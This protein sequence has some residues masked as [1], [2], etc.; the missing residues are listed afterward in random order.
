MEEEEE[1]FS[2][3]MVRRTLL[4]TFQELSRWLIGPPNTLD[5]MPLD[6]LFFWGGK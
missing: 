3:K 5:L 1:K 4:A 6:Y 2:N